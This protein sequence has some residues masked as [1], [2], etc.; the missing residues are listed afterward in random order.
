[1]HPKELHN[2]L[3]DAAEGR[4]SREAARTAIPGRNNTGPALD[5]W[6]LPNPDTDGMNRDYRSG[7]P[8]AREKSRTGA[9][10]HA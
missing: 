9:C 10:E 2:L 4:T 3:R 6:R 8:C 1:M 5:A 7:S